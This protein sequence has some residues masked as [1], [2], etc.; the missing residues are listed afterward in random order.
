MQLTVRRRD[1]LHIQMS[2]EFLQ[3]LFIGQVDT[4]VMRGEGQ[5]SVQRT[6]VQQVPAQALG[7]NPG[8]RAL[9]RTAW[10]I[11]GDDRCNVVH[12]CASCATRIPTCAHSARKFG[13]DVATLAQS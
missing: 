8:Y 11:D 1:E 3:Q 5:Q 2:G 6:G 4:M 9:A 12:D 7:Q 10:P 13:N